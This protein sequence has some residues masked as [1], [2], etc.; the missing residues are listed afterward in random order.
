MSLLNTAD[1]VYIG[2]SVVDKVYLGSNLVWQ[3]STGVDPAYGTGV[4]G[5]PLTFTTS[6]APGPYVVTDQRKRVAVVFEELETDPNTNTGY[7][8]RIDFD[9]EASNGTKLTVDWCDMTPFY[10]TVV[11]GVHYGHESE[12]R[13]GGYSTTYRFVDFQCDAGGQVTI[14][15]ITVRRIYEFSS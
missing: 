8:Y 15:N 14:N 13:V 2:N 9:I 5:E 6:G 12:G 7:P 4:Y 10:Q 3:H 1:K 11:A